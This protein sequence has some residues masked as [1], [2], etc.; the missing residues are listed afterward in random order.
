MGPVRSRHAPQ[1]APCGRV[2]RSLALRSCRAVQCQ[3]EARWTVF[4]EIRW[5]AIDRN[6]D[7]GEFRRVTQRERRRTQKWPG[8]N[9]IEHPDIGFFDSNRLRRIEA[10][11]YVVTPGS[12]YLYPGF[13]KQ[14][15]S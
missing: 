12:R 9:R 4:D 15:E 3:R 10:N 8:R 13:G 1:I 6:H 14:E 2:H 7:I 11:V 5:P